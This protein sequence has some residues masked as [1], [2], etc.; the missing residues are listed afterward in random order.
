MQGNDH[1]DWYDH[2]HRHIRNVCV[3]GVAD[4]PKLASSDYW[5]VNKFYIG[6]QSAAHHCME[7]RH[8]AIRLL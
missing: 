8:K 7:L 5:F 4:L 6:Y 2:N 1:Y 3:F